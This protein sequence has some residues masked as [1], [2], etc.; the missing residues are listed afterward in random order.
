M[1]GSNPKRMEKFLHIRTETSGKHANLNH[2][3]KGYGWRIVTAEEQNDCAGV[4]SLTYSSY[5]VK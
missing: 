1:S 2:T 3:S 4:E 5:I